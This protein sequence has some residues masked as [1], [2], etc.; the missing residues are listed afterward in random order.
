MVHFPPLLNHRLS[1]SWSRQTCIYII[2]QSKYF[3]YTILY[4]LK[5]PLRIIQK[6]QLVQNMAVQGVLGF[7][8]YAHVTP[9]LCKLCWLPVSFQ[10][11]SEYFRA[12]ITGYLRDFQSPVVGDHPI[13]SSRMGVLLNS[14]VKWHHLVSSSLLQCLPS[15]TTYPLPKFI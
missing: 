7:S 6:L 3:E 10:V 4:H 12:L 14:S 15:E 2:W 8:H 11:N 1:G 5:L 9:L 13:W